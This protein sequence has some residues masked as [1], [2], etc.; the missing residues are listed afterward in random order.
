MPFGLTNAPPTF[1]RLMT[2]VLQPFIDRF[3]VVYLDNIVIFSKTK[4][5][6]AE[7]VRLVLKALEEHKLV[8]NAKK[9]VFFQTQVEYL[10]HVVS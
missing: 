3:V 1:A 4:Q 7:H 9:S 10:G 8:A 5:E 6:H 2:E